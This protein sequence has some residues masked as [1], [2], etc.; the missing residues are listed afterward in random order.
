MNL[1][2]SNLLLL[3]VVLLIGVQTATAL[4]ITDG[5]QA[6][7]TWAMEEEEQPAEYRSV[8]KLLKY[9]I[10]IKLMNDLCDELDMCPPSQVPIRQPPVVRRGENTEMRRAPHLFWRTGV[11]HQ[12]GSKSNLKSGN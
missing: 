1:T 5:S 8:L 2:L 4:S 12:M 10:L 7:S 11:L 9:E 3:V 6:G